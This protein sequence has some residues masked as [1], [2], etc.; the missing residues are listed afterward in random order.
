MD[1]YCSQSVRK[2]YLSAELSSFSSVTDDGT[3]KVLDSLGKFKTSQTVS[4]IKDRPYRSNASDNE[5]P[6]PA[7]SREKQEAKSRETSY[8]R[9][10]TSQKNAAAKTC[11]SQSSRS[12]SVRH[13]ADKA[14]REGKTTGSSYSQT[15][16]H[17]TSDY[18][19]GSSTGSTHRPSNSKETGSSNLRGS[20]R[21]SKSPKKESSGEKRF[22]TR[23]TLKDRHQVD[24]SNKSQRNREQSI[25]TIQNDRS[26][27]NTSMY[28][29]EQ[30][31]LQKRIEELKKEIDHQ[32]SKFIEKSSHIS[33]GSLKSDKNKE[34]IVASSPS[35]RT[36]TE[37]SKHER[38]DDRASHKS[39]DYRQKAS[40]EK[41][42][43]NEMV[44]GSGDVAVKSERN[45]DSSRVSLSSHRTGAE[46]SKHQNKDERVSHKSEDYRQKASQAPQNSGSGNIGRHQR[47]NEK[48]RK[49]RSRSLGRRMEGGD[50]NI[51]SRS[52]RGLSRSRD[53]QTTRS[54]SRNHEQ[55]PKSRSH[56]SRSIERRSRRSRSHGS[57]SHSTRS[58]RSGSQDRRASSKN[59]SL[60]ECVNNDKPYTKQ[61][62]EKARESSN[63][64]SHHG[65]RCNSPVV[66]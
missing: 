11:Q 37:S 48:S 53:H 15:P 13:S 28:K 31:E 52:P 39:L 60:R 54:Q 6:G 1:Q 26:D 44:S 65:Q 49:S 12:T 59:N 51:R 22:E 50:R 10:S 42:K 4:Q 64:H 19:R 30:A 7:L 57:Q 61:E 34:Y 3:K 38:K 5:S 2:E 29:R 66:E 23:D 40:D 14:E 27:K 8:H 58:H 20:Q 36:A 21:L 45:K 62:G 41:S 16:H 47:E 18:L 63:S 33:E 9:T 32:K 56:R 24:S 43:I 17:S 25:S 55:S 46:S 35:Q